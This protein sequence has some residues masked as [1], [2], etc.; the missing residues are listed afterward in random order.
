MH[1]RT[2]VYMYVCMSVCMY[3]GM[4]ACMHVCMCWTTQ[5]TNKSQTCRP[6]WPRILSPFP[7][8]S[9]QMNRQTSEAWSRP[10]APPKSEQRVG[11]APLKEPLLKGAPGDLS[12]QYFTEGSFTG[13]AVDSKKLEPGCRMVYVGLFLLYV[14]CGVGG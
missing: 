9:R 10:S 2:C 4:H 3:V 7:R 8:W 12:L 6:W 13:I 5:I 11:R 14:A 1:A